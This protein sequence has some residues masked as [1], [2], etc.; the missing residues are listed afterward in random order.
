MP[1]QGLLSTVPAQPPWA[2]WM[3]RI[4]RRFMVFDRAKSSIVVASGSQVISVFFRSSSIPGSIGV[5]ARPELSL[6]QNVDLGD[7]PPGHADH[8]GGALQ[9]GGVPGDGE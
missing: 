1:E 9:V 8:R 4:D 6:C 7:V 5:A 2:G 3:A